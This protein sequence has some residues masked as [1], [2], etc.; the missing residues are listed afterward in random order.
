MKDSAGFSQEGASASASPHKI[1]TQ[2][3]KSPVRF[4]KA[5]LPNFK[6]IDYESVLPSKDDIAMKLEPF[7]R[8]G[9]TLYGGHIKTTMQDMQAVMSQEIYKHHKM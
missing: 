4:E 2:N 9:T 7:L 5:S 3:R 6:L 8:N 1:N